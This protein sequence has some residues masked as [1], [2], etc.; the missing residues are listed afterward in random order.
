M[1]ICFVA[2]EVAP[3]AKT[4][5]LADVSG[6]LPKYVSLR[7]CDT[8][9][10]T[11]FYST[12]PGNY[13]LQPVDYLQNVP[14]R[15]G[16]RDETFSVMTTKLPGSDV[17]VYMIVAP[18]L[19]ARGTVYTDH[20]DE[21][22]RFYFLS[23]AA[24]VCCQHMGWG[25]DIVH[26]NDW[27]TSLIPLL[28]RT[29]FHWDAMF[30]STRTVLTIHNVAYQGIFPAR[31]L[32]DI[33][34]WDHR[35]LFFQDDLADGIINYLKSGIVY[36]DILTTVSRTY[37]HEIQTPEHGAGLES[38]FR[39]R[40]GALV[41]IVNG[42]DVDEWNPE[43]DA[44]LPFHFTSDDRAGKQLNKENVV[45]RMNL[46][47]RP[48]V[49]VMGVV[50]RLTSQKGFDLFPDCIDAILAR[51]DAQMIVLGSGEKVYEEFFAR[52]EGRHPGRVRFYRGFSNELAHLIEA[53]ADIFLMPSKFEPCGLNQLYSLRYGTIPV[54]R[55]T[56]GLAD[57]VEQFDPETR[58][59][60][61]FVFEH[62]TAEGLSWGI[63]R[64]LRTYIF[65]KDA[66][67]ALVSNAMKQD[68]SWEHQVSEYLAVYTRLTM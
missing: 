5:G 17:D 62:F 12:T 10:F 21:Y 6:T 42:V 25:P 3:F 47:V 54:V 46:P 35:H 26:C 66:W 57:T 39:R 58:E 18:H 40:G 67:N 48:D 41:G 16:H 2:S 44:F 4:G 22:M 52:L 13:D 15:I 27:Q 32:H 51:Y 11:P 50:S 43:T 24:L 36:A 14:V 33:G 8:R 65:D 1:N 31:V 59:G 61:G 20:A 55:K 23:H 30:K 63:E 38:L 60:T 45:S 29:T 19:Y 68:F 7:G 64:A 37:A 9:V 53:G 34:L 56:G 49:P 28:L